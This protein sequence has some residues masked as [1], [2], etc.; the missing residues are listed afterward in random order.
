MP[1]D[2]RRP[3]VVVVGLGPAG[4]D[5]VTAAATDAI[6]RAGRRFLRT[7]RHPAAPVVG[8]AESFDHLYARAESLGEVYAGIVAALV[9]A[10]ERARAVLLAVPRHP[11][12]P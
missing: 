7:R 5:L 3:T 10:A 1:D 11:A 8:E 6:A 12:V 9:A 2:G 4:P